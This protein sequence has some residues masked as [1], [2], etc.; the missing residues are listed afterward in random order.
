[1]RFDRSRLPGEGKRRQRGVW[2]LGRVVKEKVRTAP[3]PYPMPPLHAWHVVFSVN[4]KPG[5]QQSPS[6][7]LPTTRKNGRRSSGGGGRAVGKLGRVDRGKRLG[8]PQCAR[9]FT[10]CPFLMLLLAQSPPLRADHR[11]NISLFPSAFRGL[12]HYASNS[13]S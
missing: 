5:R 3:M 11:G 13:T 12:K 10:Q 6:G 4:Y 7:T 9:C 1:M 2:E 8:R